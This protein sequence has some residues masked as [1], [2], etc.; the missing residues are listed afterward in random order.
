MKNI[1]LILIFLTMILLLGG[2]IIKEYYV[3]NE[4]NNIDDA[5]K[6]KEEYESLNNIK[7]G[8]NK[9]PNVEISSDN[10]IVYV[11][12]D[13]VEEI[14]IKGTGVIYFGFPECP[15]CRNAVP[16]LLKA[17][18]DVGIDKVY[19]FNALE[20]RDVKSLDANGNIVVEKEGTKEYEKLINI[21]YDYLG[22][23]EGLNN[24]MIKR[25][26]FPTVIFV[27][28]GTIIGSHIGTLDSQTNPYKLLNET[29]KNEL[30]DIYTDYMLK[31]LGIICNTDAKEKC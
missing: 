7:F 21:L 11:D 14:I 28:D 17:V 31:M 29:E 10:P 24:E 22:E 26:Y 3:K 13:Q 8:K 25:L 23:Y 15:W 9:Y 4:I 16:Q 12:Y 30:V 18:E 20:I 27:K 1:K 2:I 5:L 19:Y 6:F